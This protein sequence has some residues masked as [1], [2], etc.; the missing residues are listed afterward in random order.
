MSE[1]STLNVKLILIELRRCMQTVR[2]QL[3]K[4]RNAK[5][6]QL[7]TSNHISQNKFRIVSHVTAQIWG[8]HAIDILMDSPTF[9]HI[10]EYPEETWRRTP[11]VYT[12]LIT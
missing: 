8:E 4:A 3:H 1:E 10:K 5:Q 12:W 7:E 9:L 6:Y 11:Y 2:L